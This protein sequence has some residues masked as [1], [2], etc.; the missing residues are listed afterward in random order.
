MAR[1]NG[2]TTT[3]NFF[4]TT[5]TNILRVGAF[6]AWPRGGWYTRSDRQARQGANTGPRNESVGKPHQKKKEKKNDDGCVVCV[7]TT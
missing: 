5:S 4:Q 7:A 6:F 1:Q 3:R 2:K